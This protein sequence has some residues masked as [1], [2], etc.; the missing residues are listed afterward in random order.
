MAST[1]PHASFVAPGSGDRWNIVGE[2]LTVKL[3]GA[4]T[5]NAYAV[6]EQETPA[7]GSVPRHVHR[8]EDEGFYVLEGQYEFRVGNDTIRAEAGA[9]L[10]AP[11]G[12]PHALRNAGNGPARLLV[13]ISPPGFEEF[14]EEVD[15]ATR[16]GPMPPEQLAALAR[17][18]GVEFLTE[19]I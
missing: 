3:R 18:Y 7:G 13:T 14:F 17:N 8:R 12:I 9:Y 2:R 19:R 1:I 6:L 15:R 5:G 4:Q 11:R 16:T 10:F